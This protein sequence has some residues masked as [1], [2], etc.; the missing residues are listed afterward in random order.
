[1]ARLVLPHRVPG[2]RVAT[3]TLTI[4][5]LAPMAAACAHPA[6]AG[7]AVTSG[8]SQPP[9]SALLA[10]PPGDDESL[11][12]TDYPTPIEPSDPVFLAPSTLATPTATPRPVRTDGIV[13]LPP[14]IV[15]SPPATPP[16]TPPSSSPG[17][18]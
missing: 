8:P 5:L 9:T 7:G 17:R 1:M 11:P 12:V 3:A 2:R 14:A 13:V 15:L 10:S 16:E 18:T 4:S 6:P